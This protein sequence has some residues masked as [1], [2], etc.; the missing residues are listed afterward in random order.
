MPLT[1]TTKS[2][3][4]N[5]ELKKRTTQRLHVEAFGSHNG[6]DLTQAKQMLSRSLKMKD[7]VYTELVSNELQ[8]SIHVHSSLER[9]RCIAL[10]NR[11][12]IILVRSNF[13]PECSV[14]H[15]FGKNQNL[16]KTL[17]KVHFTK[18]LGASAAI[19]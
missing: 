9:R 6:E 11:Q 13:R 2:A 8:R 10:A 1:L 18:D 16:N 17:L 5:S 19:Q 7:Q 12:H 15:M 4:S 14:I 3:K